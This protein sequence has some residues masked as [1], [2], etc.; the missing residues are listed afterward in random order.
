MKRLRVAVAQFNAHVGDLAGNAA[1]IV[2]LAARA[3]DGGA[4]VLLTPELA[5]SGY[6]PEDLLDEAGFLS[7]LRG[8]NRCSGAR[9][10][11]TRRGRLS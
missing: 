9:R 6:P 8:G 7:R 1:R 2:E 5:L 3:R 10:H 4:D 11:A